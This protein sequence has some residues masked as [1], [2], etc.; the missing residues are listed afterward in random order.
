MSGT[1]GYAD[2]S[3]VVNQQQLGNQLLAAIVQ[4]LK[5]GVLLST[6]LPPL[7]NAVNDA[8]AATAGVPV[9]GMY[10]NGS[11]LMVRVT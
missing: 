9:N 8:A 4:Q 11:V 2:L 10:R 3:S 6:N 5:A 7:T 1:V